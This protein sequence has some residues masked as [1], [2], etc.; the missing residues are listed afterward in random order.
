MDIEEIVGTIR[1]HWEKEWKKEKS[2]HVAS[3]HNAVVDVLAQ[4]KAHIDEIIIALQILLRET[5]DE[6]MTQIHSES[7]IAVE[8][9]PSPIHGVK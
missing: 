7:K 9:L 6:K 8:P 4:H 5:I 1:D 2:E 3:I